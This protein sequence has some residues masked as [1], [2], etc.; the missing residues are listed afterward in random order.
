VPLRW[1]HV[2]HGGIRELQ[3]RN[4]GP[5]MRATLLQCD[6]GINL[7]ERARGLLGVPVF[8]PAVSERVINLPRLRFCVPD[9]RR[10]A[11]DRGLLRRPGAGVRRVGEY[12]FGL[13][14]MFDGCEGLPPVSAERPFRGELR[15]R[16]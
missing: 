16:L 6:D 14:A 7:P 12:V 11:T 4:V 1:M 15:H 2:S 10:G 13:R 9:E 3:V 8:R 5:Q